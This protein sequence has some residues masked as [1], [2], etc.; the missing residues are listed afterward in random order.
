LPELLLQAHLY[1]PSLGHFEFA[2]CRAEHQQAADGVRR[3]RVL[4]VYRE[5]WGDVVD[6]AKAIADVRIAAVE[7]P[8]VLD[9]VIAPHVGVVVAQ[10]PQPRPLRG[11]LQP[12]FHEQGILQ[13]LV[14]L[15]GQRRLVAVEMTWYG[16]VR[17]DRARASGVG[18]VA[19]LEPAAIDVEADR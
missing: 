2:V 17:V 5:A 13:G 18:V 12:V 14:A 9:Q 1:L 3:L 11:K 10:A 7:G 6:R 19:V 4:G 8:R 16:F 15:A